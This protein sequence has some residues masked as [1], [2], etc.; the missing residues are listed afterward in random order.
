MMQ[1]FCATLLIFIR[2]ELA[3]RAYYAMREF[4]KVNF[5]KNIGLGSKQDAIKPEP[6][7]TSL[8]SDYRRIF[9][10]LSAQSENSTFSLRVDW[11]YWIFSQTHLLCLRLFERFLR[12]V[13]NKGSRNDEIDESGI[14]KM[15]VSLELID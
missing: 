8:L 1:D 9:N 13:R 3:S 15:R 5:S 11:V 2:C 14:E 4:V 7:I 12:F 6:A 10:L